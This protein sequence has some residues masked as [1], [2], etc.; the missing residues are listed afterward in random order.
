MPAFV[1]VKSKRA[2]WRSVPESKTPSAVA[3]CAISSLSTNVT[4]SPT[5]TS[6]DLGAKVESVISTI[7]SA[8]VAAAGLVP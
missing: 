6:I 2:P 7:V 4:V 8:D 3:V 1:A 5:Y